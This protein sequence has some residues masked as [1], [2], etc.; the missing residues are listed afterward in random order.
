MLIK[1][2]SPLL[3]RN[4]ALVTFDELLIVFSAKVNLLHLLYSTAQ[5]C[6]LLHLIK[7]NC[8]LKT[9]LR[10]IQGC[11]HLF[12]LKFKVFKAILG[13]FKPIFK[14]IENI[15]KVIL[16]E[17]GFF[18]MPCTKKAMFKAILNLLGIQESMLFGL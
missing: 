14:A 1:Q 11:Q 2:K 10:T 13:K 4:M 8:L 3:P 15:F 5:R 6:C 7:Q 12:R 18:L 16:C 17:F 9:F